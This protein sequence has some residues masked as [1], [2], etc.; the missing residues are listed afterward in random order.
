MQ[1]L[2]L[3]SVLNFPT[4]LGKLNPRNSHQFAADETDGAFL[5]RLATVAADTL[6]GG[7]EDVVVLVGQ[8]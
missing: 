2:K 8:P 6:L 1:S 4:I 7:Q 5:W 3:F